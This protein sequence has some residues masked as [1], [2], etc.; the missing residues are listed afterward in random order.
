MDFESFPF[1]I[2]WELTLACNL[3][4]RH[5][6]SSAGGPRQQ[7]LTL[8]ESLAICDQFPPLFVEEVIFTGGEPLLN[9]HWAA[10]ASRLRGLNIKTGMVTNGLCITDQTV[11]SMKECGLTA[12]GV[13]LDGDASVH[14][15]I[16]GLPGAFDRAVAGIER[17]VAGGIDVTLITSVTGIN[18]D[19]LE[20]IYRVVSSLGAWK[21]QLQPL[22]ALGRGSAADELRLTDEQFLGLGRFIADICPRAAENGLQVVPADSCG[23]CSPFDL[24]D[25]TWSGCCAGRFGCGIMSDGAVKGCLSW[26][27]WTVEGDLRKDDLWTIWFRPGAFEKL[28]KVAR[29]D[30]QGACRSCDMAMECGGGCQAMSIA[31]T[32]GWRGDPY[33][34]RRILS[35]RPGSIAPGSSLQGERACQ[36]RG[37]PAS[38]LPRP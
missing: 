21:W 4:C 2:G 18:A 38:S 34:Y 17:L 6:A 24:P 23:Y 8:A 35:E 31:S 27:D 16:R 5:C 12:A 26:P 3:R 33:C 14:D 28:R 29:E 30:L 7:E 20:E 10:I 11:G 15:R 22:F 19:R 37:L 25:F 1:V 36:V 13:S 9:P 32:G